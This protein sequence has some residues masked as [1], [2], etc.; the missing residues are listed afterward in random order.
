MRSICLPRFMAD[1]RNQEVDNFLAQL[2]SL[3]Q[4]VFGNC[5]GACWMRQVGPPNARGNVVDLLEP[6]PGPVRG[7]SVITNSHVC[8]PLNSRAQCHSMSYTCHS[9]LE[10]VFEPIAP[11]RW[12]GQLALFLCFAWHDV[13]P[14]P[15]LLPICPAVG[16][17]MPAAK[18]ELARGV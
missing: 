5:P 4:K 12:S 17:G 8:W 15:Y 7:P 16:S 6:C 9:Q 18:S 1:M 2:W 13:P 10:A 14:T 3:D 11:D